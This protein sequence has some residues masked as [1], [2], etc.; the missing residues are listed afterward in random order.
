LR[1][2]QQDIAAARPLSFVDNLSNVVCQRSVP[3]LSFVRRHL[4]SKRIKPLSVIAEMRANQ[5][6]DLFSCG[7]GAVQR[8]NTESLGRVKR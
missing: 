7:H 5:S 3:L 4:E 1:E 8:K 2:L 6:L